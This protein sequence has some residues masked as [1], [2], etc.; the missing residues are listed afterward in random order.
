MRIDCRRHPA[1]SVHLQP[2]HAGIG[3][4]A[5]MARRF[6]LRNVGQV[7]AGLGAGGTDVT[8][9]ARLAGRSSTVRARVAGLGKVMD[10][11]PERAAGADEE[12]VRVAVGKF[13]Q[14]ERG[15]ASG[16]P[17]IVR[18]TRHA[19]RSLG[20]PV[21]RLEVVVGDRPV[22]ADTVERAESEILGVEADGIA[23]PVQRASAD[24]SRPPP[25]QQIRVRAA[26]AV[27]IEARQRT[28]PWVLVPEVATHVR[29][30]L[31]EVVPRTCFQDGD[32]DPAPAELGRHDAARGPG[33]DD[34]D[35][36]V[37]FGKRPRRGRR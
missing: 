26:G 16:G 14:R 1:G 37:H 30:A 7:H 3:N 28:P 12:T 33:S 29:R 15:A 18:D 22:V 27:A 25:L 17:R 9:A 11:H 2:E 6:G 10:R 32:A 34:A 8:G 13:G 4:D 21:V 35:L 20:A 31:R 36:G 23:F 19:E 5:D 24:A